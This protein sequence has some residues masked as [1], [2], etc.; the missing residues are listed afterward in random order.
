MDNCLQQPGL[1]L[2]QLK[3]PMRETKTQLI[4]LSVL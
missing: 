4:K 2:N 1:L 3:R